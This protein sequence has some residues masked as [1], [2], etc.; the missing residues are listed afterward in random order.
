MEIFD[1]VL[2]AYDEELSQLKETLGNGSAEDYPHYR[3]LVGSI[4][5]IEWAKQTLKNVLKKTME[6]D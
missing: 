5:S 1:K 2:K 4:A 6:D 3:Q